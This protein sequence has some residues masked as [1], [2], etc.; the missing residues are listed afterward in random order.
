[1]LSSIKFTFSGLALSK[2]RVVIDKAAVRLCVSSRK[3]ARS[4]GSV[5]VE[6]WEMTVSCCSLSSLVA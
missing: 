6:R 5:S 4:V 1:M 2:A 3:V